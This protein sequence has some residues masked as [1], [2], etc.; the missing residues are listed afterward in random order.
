MSQ[1]IIGLDPEEPVFQIAGR[2]DC[3]DGYNLSESAPHGFKPTVKKGIV[4]A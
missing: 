1:G 3:H 4:D 2:E